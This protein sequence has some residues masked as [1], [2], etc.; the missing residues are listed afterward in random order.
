[1]IKPIDWISSDRERH[2]FIVSACGT[3]LVFRQ[4][5]QD[6]LKYCCFMKFI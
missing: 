3:Y 1:M 2:I 4:V 6:Y 5:F